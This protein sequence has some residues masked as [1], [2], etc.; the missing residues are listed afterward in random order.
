MALSHTH[1]S[2]RGA[3]LREE[4]ADVLLAPG[5]VLVDAAV[6][7]PAAMMR[8]TGTGAV[9]GADFF[10]FWGGLS[11]RD[12]RVG[13][14][15]ASVSVSVALSVGVHIYL[16]PYDGH[17]TPY[18]PYGVEDEADGDFDG[19]RNGLFRE[20]RGRGTSSTKEFRTGLE[21]MLFDRIKYSTL[22]CVEGMLLY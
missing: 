13:I 12:R 11:D 7:P 21:C 9:A 15:A 17:D 10:F 14:N 20:M 19:E 6:P 22:S 5:F 16:S 4:R 8:T 3:D 18:T 2:V 1:Y